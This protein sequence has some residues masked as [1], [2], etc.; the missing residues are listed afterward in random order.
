MK[1]ALIEQGF[2]PKGTKNNQLVLWEASERKEMEKILSNHKFVRAEKQD[3]HKHMT[4]VYA[5]TKTA[6]ART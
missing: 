6:A 1:A 4:V 5:D 2:V 3:Y